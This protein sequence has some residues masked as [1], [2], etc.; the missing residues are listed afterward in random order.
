LNCI[1]DIRVTEFR[2]KFHFRRP[3]PYHLEPALQPLARIKSPSFASGHS[4]W[5]FTEAFIFS[6][7]IPDKRNLFLAKAEEVR[8]SRELMGIHY[9]SDNEASRVIGWYLLKFWYNN[10]QFREDMKKA[11]E[12]WK[13]KRSKF[14]Q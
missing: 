12:E 5:A 11:K 13:I 7:I 1:Q 4:L 14:Q 3:R 8:W 9:P 2:L 10:A 6:E